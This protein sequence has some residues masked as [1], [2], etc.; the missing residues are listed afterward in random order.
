MESSLI[1]FILVGIF[2]IC[3][4][5]LSLNPFL[6]FSPLFFGWLGFCLSRW[7][8]KEKELTFPWLLFSLIFSVLA[9]VNLLFSLFLFGLSFWF[10]I[11]F[12]ERLIRLTGFLKIFT[13]SILFLL[14]CLIILFI[15]LNLRLVG[16]WQLGQ[17]FLGA[18]I[19]SLVLNFIDLL[20]FK[21][22]ENKKK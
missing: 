17:W 6:S 3:L 9:N 7:R 2:F 13:G 14:I 4:E 11:F 21:I 20:V 22:N 15:G 5:T 10:L 18:L 16:P 12:Q 19:V 8:F 1:L